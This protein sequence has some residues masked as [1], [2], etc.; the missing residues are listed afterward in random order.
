MLVLNLFY[1]IYLFIADH[2]QIKSKLQRE[3]ERL[4]K[5]L[6]TATGDNTC[7]KE[8]NKVQSEII[9]RQERAMT[10]EATIDVN[11]AQIFK[12]EDIVQT[13]LYYK[14]NLDKENKLMKRQIQQQK[15]NHK[16]STAMLR[17]RDRRVMNAPAY[18][19]WPSIV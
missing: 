4:R 2:F 11:R 1:C 12:P 7:L 9:M 15:Q 17:R 14:V 16:K 13:W 6:E 19:T 8:S 18:V 5:Q 10:S 3:S